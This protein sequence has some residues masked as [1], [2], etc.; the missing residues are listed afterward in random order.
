MEAEVFATDRL[1]LRRLSPDDAPFILE[2]VND[3]DWLRFIGDRNVRNLDDARE[4][5]RKGPVDSY[6][7]LGFGLYAMVRRDGGP[8]IGMCGLLRR[9]FLEDADIGFA[10]L[11]AHRGRGYAREAAR[12]TLVYAR[13]ELGLGRIVAITSRDNERSGRLLEEV[14]LRF[15]RMIRIP[16]PPSEEVRLYGSDD[17]RSGNLPAR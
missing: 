4:Y 9:D 11:P 10:L 5:I 17:P 6:A 3:P 8:P 12:A 16:G 7:R 2:L 1:I 13:D 15:E 14:G